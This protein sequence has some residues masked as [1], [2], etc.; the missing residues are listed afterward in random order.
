MRIASVS[1]VLLLTTVSMASAQRGFQGPP[2]MVKEGATLKVSDHVYVIPD[3]DVPIVP[4]V[5]IIVGS[6]GTL[7]VDTGLGP[8]NAQV[9][10]REVAKVSRN[11]ELYFVATHFHPEHAGGGSG[12]PASAKFIVA[13]VQQQELDEQGAEMNKLFAGFSPV[14]ADLLKD[15]QMRHGDIMFEREYMLDLG[16]LRARITAPGSMH[17]RGDTIIFVEGDRVLFA[18][19]VVMNRRFLAFG[20]TAS[21]KTWI[22]VLKDLAAL[23]P[24]LVVP[25]HGSNGDAMII[26]QQQTLLEAMVKRVGELKAQGKSLDETQ[27]TVTGEIQA[28]YADWTGGQQGIPAA[29][30]AMYAEAR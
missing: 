6:R 29:I 4:N 12:F 8:K 23:K 16:G 30:R 27:K 1:F 26:D 28:R 11:G 2:P 9:I 13:R 14:T 21:P 5:G 19:D 7:V 22:E 20:P 25:S 17:T 3:G 24:A 15:V 10:L 18:G